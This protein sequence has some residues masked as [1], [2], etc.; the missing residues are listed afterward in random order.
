MRTRR[1]PSLRAAPLAWV[2]TTSAQAGTPVFANVTV[3]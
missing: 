1:V 3:P 2:G